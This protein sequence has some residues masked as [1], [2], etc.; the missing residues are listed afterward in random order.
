MK[1]INVAEAKARL[2]SLIDAA[3]SGEEIIIAKRGVP[4]VT[5]RPVQQTAGGRRLGTA[6]G[7]VHLSDD[8]DDTPDEFA[9]YL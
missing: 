7:L 3:L 1:S 5:L 8:F 6:K 2:S 4:L 9:E